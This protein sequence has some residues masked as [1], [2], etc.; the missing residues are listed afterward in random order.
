MFGMPGGAE[1]AIIAVVVMLVFRK[2]IP[3]SMRSLGKGVFEFKKAIGG[4]R[5]KI[6]K[7]INKN[8]DIKE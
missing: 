3:G 5:N 8:S 6:S 4:N 2:K 1:I 7:I